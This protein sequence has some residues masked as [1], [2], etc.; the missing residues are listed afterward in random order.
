MTQTHKP[1][2]ASESD[3][4]FQMKLSKLYQELNNLPKHEQGWQRLKERLLRTPYYRER[5]KK[6]GD[7]LFKQLHGSVLGM[8]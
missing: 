4:D 2:A 7:L 8:E 3:D 6:E 5:Y 1:S